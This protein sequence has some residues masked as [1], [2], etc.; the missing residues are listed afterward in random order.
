MSKI[1]DIK[2][3]EILDS[4][5]DP[6]VEATVVFESGAVGSAKVPSGASVGKFEAHEKR[7]GDE[8]R[9]L[10]RGVLSAVG[11]VNGSIREALI[12]MNG[13]N[14]RLIDTTMLELDGTENKEA[15]GANATLA[16]SIAVARAAANHRNIP[17]Y[18]HLGGA[19]GRSLPIPMLNIINGGAHASNNLD[20]QEF[21]IIPIG[22]I[23]F[24][25]RIRKSAEIYKTLGKILKQKGYATTVG[26]EGGYAPSL[27]NDEH[28]LAL[29]MQAVAEAGYTDREI[30]LGLDIASSE[31]CKDGKYELPKRRVKLTAEELCDYYER[32]IEKYPMI[33]I[34]DGVGEEDY[35]GWRRLTKRLGKDVALIGDDLFVT[36]KERLLMGI[37]NGLGNGILIKPNQIGTVT[38]TFDVVKTAKEN[39]YRVIA[40]HRSGET[41]DTF[42]ADL[43]VGLGTPYIKSGAPARS[44]R[45]SK[46][47]RLCE[48]EEEISEKA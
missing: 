12:G 35:D 16:V 23:P 21:M 25:E 31:W 33:S 19:L 28:A 27:E 8:K 37:K 32:L 39:G 30:K 48:I 29:I 7:D 38:E 10:G 20:I 41:E 17:L 6:T 9:Y 5:G 4:R 1:K 2:A 46:Y 18:E 22:D 3:R 36:N 13:E 43:A 42:I 11:A 15:L 47:N 45:L 44:E 34:E 40:S 26:D 14:L 24:R